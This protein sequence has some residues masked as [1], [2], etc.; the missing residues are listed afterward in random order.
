VSLIL[1]DEARARMLARVKPLEPEQV[2]LNE[3]AGR[4]LAEKVTASRPQPPFDASA[5]DGWAVRAADA[6]QGARLKIAGESAAGHGYSGTLESGEAVR[7]FTGAPVPAGADTIVIQENA[8][9]EGDVV[10]IDEA[11]EAARHIRPAGGDFQAGDVL[12]EPGV[13]LDA[14]RISLAAAAGK[15]ILAVARRPKVAILSTGEE[16][17]LPGAAPGPYQIFNSGGPALAALVES[18]G[19]EAEVLALA[20]DDVEVIAGAVAAATCDVVVTIG[21]ASV[22]DHDLVKP[23]LS[24]LGLT[25]AF[26]KLKMRPGKPTSFG[27]L[28]DGR[29]VLGLPGNPAS[30]LVC[31]QLFLKSLIAA[32][33]G[34]DPDLGLVSARTAAGL[35]ANGP[36]E[37]WIR[38]RLVNADGGW[39]ITP[40]S[41]Q[42]SSLVTV[43]ASA[44]ALLRRLADA[45]AVKAGEV[46]EVLR[47]ERL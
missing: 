44:D 45:P 9:R 2:S 6:T 38:A 33:S 10:A 5:M 1:V 14:W 40:F 21:G 31:A 28:A 20:G 22:G 8:T 3:A 29:Y 27:T 36:R 32:M 24:K 47:L 42:D 34:A 7:I 26:E 12:L 4:V 15:P 25:L 16:I 39:L 41:D 23:A 13:R 30:A 46:V 19:G 18:W 37:H 35:P 43:F 17:V 11:A